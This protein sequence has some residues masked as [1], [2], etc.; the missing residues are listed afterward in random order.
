M[1]AAGGPN[2]L[3]ESNLV[4]A[5]DTGDVS[6]S[7]IGEPTVNLHPYSIDVSNWTGDLFGNWISSIVT[8]DA[9]IAPDKTLTGDILGN[10][11]GR[12]NSSTTIAPSQIYTYTVYL[13]N[14]SLTNDFGIFYSYGLNGGLVSYGQGISVSIASLSTTEWTRFTLTT[15]APSSG[16]N[17]VQLGPCPF[18]G[19]GNPSGQQIAVWGGM[20]E[21]KNHATPFVNGT[22]SAT[23]GLLPLIGTSTIDLT[24]VS[25]DSN[26]Q[27]EFDG[28][29]DFI[30]TNFPATTLNTPTIE[31][32]VYR[33]T[34]TGRYEAIVQSNLASDDALY[35]YPQIGIF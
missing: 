4:F 8:S 15:A 12:F 10:G 18:T 11:Y 33:S 24:N 34:A 7:Y 35:V 28:T 22:R 32:V 3:G 1:P 29:N 13:K 30:D 26:A 31:A 17:Q 9:V 19:Y 23:Q 20:I 27:I 16:V 25:F 5:Y 14:I 6:N 2:T 21:L